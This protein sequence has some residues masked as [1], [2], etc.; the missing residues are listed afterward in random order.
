MECLRKQPTYHSPSVSP[1]PPSLSPCKADPIS[2]PGWVHQVQKKGSL[3]EHNFGH[4]ASTEF[5][6]ARHKTGGR[7]KLAVRNFRENALLDALHVSRS[8]KIILVYFCF[9]GCLPFNFSIFSAFHFNEKK[10]K[11]WLFIQD[12]KWKNHPDS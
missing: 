5:G 10:C 1:F 4:T 11:L 6:K 12:F 3:M 2:F 9:C 7:R 8:T